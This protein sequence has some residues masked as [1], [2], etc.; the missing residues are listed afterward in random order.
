MPSR[1]RD[2][3][4][5]AERNLRSAEVNYQA[6]L[7]EESC[8]ESQQAAEKAVKGFLNYL[9]K[10]MKGHS[11]TLLLQAL[12]INIPEEILTCAQEL[13]KHYIPSRYPDVYDEGAPADYY[14]KGNAEKCINCAKSILN[15]VKDVVR[16]L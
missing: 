2:W 14:N 11:V 10:E 16:G 3:L 5:Q 6:G 15:W 8:Y 1:T 4:R 9:H 12:G 7:Y 13:D